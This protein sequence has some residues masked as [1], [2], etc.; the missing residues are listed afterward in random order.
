MLRLQGVGCEYRRQL[1]GGNALELDDR[2]GCCAIVQNPPGER[3]RKQTHLHLVQHTNPAAG[4]RDD[5]VRKQVDVDALDPVRLH[6]LE[7]EPREVAGAS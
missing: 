1:P 6:V 3:G 7:A 2:R 4:D 5:L